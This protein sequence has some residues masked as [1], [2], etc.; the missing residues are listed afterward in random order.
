MTQ[1]IFEK[2]VARE[3]P[4][5][6]IYEDADHLAFLN[7][8]PFEKGHTLVIPKKAYKTIFEMPED[9]YLEL[10]KVVHRVAKHIKKVLECDMNVLQN[11]GEV[12]GQEVLHVHFHIVPRLQNKDVYTSGNDDLYESDEEKHKYG[13]MLKMDA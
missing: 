11:N 9:E 5:D 13:S 6:I 10:Q 1:T 8:M 4:A 7:I 2:I 3:L 12:S